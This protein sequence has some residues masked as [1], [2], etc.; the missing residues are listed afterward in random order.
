MMLKAALSMTI[1]IKCLFY[2][3]LIILCFSVGA[4]HSLASD[5]DIIVIN[6][7]DIKKIEISKI[8]PE[9]C[10]I[11]HESYTPRSRPFK[12][13]G[14]VASK[15]PDSDYKTFYH[16]DI[17]GPKQWFINYFVDHGKF[18]LKNID[19]FR[20]INELSKI[21]GRPQMAIP[22]MDAIF[23]GA[24]PTMLYRWRLINPAAQDRTVAV[25][26]VAA[27]IRGSDLKFDNID[28]MIIVFFEV[29]S[30]PTIPGGSSPT[31][32]GGG[33]SHSPLKITGTTS[34]N[35]KTDNR[36]HKTDSEP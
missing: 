31:I 10:D 13:V 9:G 29:L 8:T 2:L 6:A 5:T 30:S 27:S 17:F 7:Y 11:L 12:L 14:P 26:I 3:L 16:E 22:F 32:P 23:V 34:M 20:S 19:K 1:Q 28:Y 36:T 25:E 24:K 33:L 18:D 21:C 15:I 35:Q 4:Q